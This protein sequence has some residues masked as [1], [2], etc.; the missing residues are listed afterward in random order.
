MSTMLNHSQLLKRV[1][2][3]LIR[4]MKCN[5]HY[6]FLI[7]LRLKGWS[8]IYGILNF[9]RYLI[10]VELSEI[11]YTILNRAVLVHVHRPNH[12]QMWH[13]VNRMDWIWFSNF[14][15]NNYLVQHIICFV[16]ICIKHRIEYMSVGRRH[17][18]CYKYYIIIDWFHWVE[19]MCVFCFWFYI[20]I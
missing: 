10:F 19:R 12:H 3:S 4:F 13:G 1:V 16:D 14:N 9:P 11:Q 18:L 2:A 5:V 8:G 20:F 6:R 17:D 15:W 7:N